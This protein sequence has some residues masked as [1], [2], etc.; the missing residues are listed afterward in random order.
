MASFFRTPWVSWQQKGLTN[1]DFD[2][3]G[4]D[5]VAVA[6]AKPHANHLHFT[7]DR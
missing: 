4:D 2:K 7:S 6:L 3:A 1:Q 5:D